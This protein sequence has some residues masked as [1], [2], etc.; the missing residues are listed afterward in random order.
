MANNKPVRFQLRK[1][2]SPLSDDTQAVSLVLGP[3][4]VKFGWIANSP[5]SGK[6]QPNE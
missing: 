5:I 1:L 3:L 4:S 6:S 2:Q